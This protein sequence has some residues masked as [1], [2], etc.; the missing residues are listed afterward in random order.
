MANLTAI[1]LTLNESENIVDC[2]QSVQTLAE[3]VI[4][5]DSGSSDDTV[6]KAESAGAD[7]YT[8]PF[9]NHAAQFNWGLEH[10]DISTQWVL[11]I[12]ADERFT[13][14]LCEEAES[15]MKQYAK[16]D[17]NG[18]VIKF[19]VFFLGRW[20]RYGGAYP[21]CKLLIFKYGSGRSENRKMDEHIRLD[22]GDVIELKNDALHYA[23]KNLTY[24][25]A[26]HNWYSSKEMQQYYE[27]DNEQSISQLSGEE[28]K[29]K[30]RQKTAYYKL[31]LFYRAFMLFIY[32]YIFRLGF[33]DGKEGLI[34]HF[35]Q[36]FWYRFLVDAK[37]YE[38]QKSQSVL[39]EA[40][41]LK[42]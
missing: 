27:D 25:I 7:V 15:A 31:P 21:F 3:R 8:H 41:V 39:E 38:Q 10:T 33:L 32:T 37:I 22:H 35:L 13:K 28:L 34:Y 18:M 23:F 36:C 30:R 40:G 19:K 2:I 11:R 4:V 29:K 5:I 1:I 14:S 42:E 24:F 17:I 16:S 12:D 20:I 9:I 6:A 26:K